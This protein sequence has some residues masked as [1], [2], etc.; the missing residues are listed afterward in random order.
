MFDGLF[1]RRRGLIGQ[2]LLDAGLVTHNELKKA[3]KI[4]KEKGSLLGETLIRLNH[5]SDAD[6]KIALQEQLS[7]SIVPIKKEDLDTSEATEFYRLH[8]N[9]KFALFSDDP[10]KSLMITS[11]VPKEGKSMTVAYFAL[12]M[13]NVMQKKTLLIDADMR[14]PSIDLQFGFR[15]DHGLADLINNIL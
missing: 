12:V 4:S 2:I 6:L 3:I 15:A 14:H 5:I 9:V 8:T 10:I 11:A 7:M 1:N 13:A